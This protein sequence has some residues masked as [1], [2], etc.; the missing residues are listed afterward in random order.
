MHKHTHK[1][2][3]TTFGTLNSRLIGTSNKWVL[4]GREGRDVMTGS[5]AVFVYLNKEVTALTVSHHSWLL[6]AESSE[7]NTCCF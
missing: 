4:I 3:H 2:V 5:V 7:R 6:A 1:H